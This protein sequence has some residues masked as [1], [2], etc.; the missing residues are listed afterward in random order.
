MGQMDRRIRILRRLR[1]GERLAAIAGALPHGSDAEREAISLLLVELA[2]TEPAGGAGSQV[3][4]GAVRTLAIQ[5]RFVPT[6]LRQLALA[7]C[8]GAW[9]EA[10]AGLEERAIAE[11]GVSLAE[12]VIDSSDPAAA[13][14]LPRVLEQ[15]DAGAAAAAAQ[16]LLALAIRL[17][18]Q[19]EPALLGLERRAPALRPALDPDV[20]SWS[21]A[22]FRLV[23]DAVTRGVDSF[24]AHRRKELLLAALLLL[25]RPST[26]LQDTPLRALVS[27]PGSA[28]GRTLRSAL[29]RGRA[30]IARGRAWDWLRETAVAGA[31]AERLA[32]APTVAD[33]AAVLEAGHLALAPAREA[34]LRLIP[35]S[36]RPAPAETV[37]PGA[38]GLRRR[39]HPDGPAPDRVSLQLLGFAAR[40]RTP[41]FVACL[42]ADEASRDL[43]L[44]PFLTDPDPVVRL[45]ASRVVSATA[46]RDFCLDGCEAIA[47]SAAFAVSACGVPESGRLRAGDAGR[48][49]FARVL[50]R[51]PHGPVR[52]IG[53]EE[54]DRL[55]PG[56]RNAS[57]AIAARRAF[58]ADASTFVD[59]VRDT[60]RSG[61]ADASVGALMTARRIRVVS[62]IEPL[63]LSIIRESL[64][65]RSAAP[66]RLVATAVACLGDLRA[67]RAA[68]VLA[69]CLARHHDPRVRSNAAEAF[70]RC[71]RGEPLDGALEAS[72]ADAHH[73]VRASA[74][75]TLLAPWPEPKPGAGASG[76]SVGALGEM[77][78]DA[79]A[80]HRL[81]GVWVVQRSLSAGMR[82]VIGRR[83]QEV[84]A[85]VRWLADGDADEAVRARAG[86]VVRRLDAALA[87][88]GP[89]GAGGLDP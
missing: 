69:E 31:C 17:T 66:E 62:E 87:G 60:V 15:G 13:G 81:A 30:P 43:A 38:E 83:W 85:R 89:G 64:H 56:C 77:L 16:A 9:A 12:L 50:E 67:G 3:R 6:A 58:A 55:T 36:T 40:R 70:A 75:R 20:P 2:A 42:E 41:R 21:D 86:A 28:A 79:R 29:R 44:D 10:I 63:A 82:G 37:P 23:L 35:L 27:D 76:A 25:E 52:W 72:L 59:W 84:T 71:R 49:R 34:G 19:D 22:E 88:L 57:R 7:A 74:V 61:D 14:A 53:V 80:P 47:R 24:D 8:R 18:G 48:R 46:A 5:W 54:S 65:G 32:R 78:L 73:R 1:P 33:H 51:S 39:V 68:G 26:C 4:V 45:A 11:G